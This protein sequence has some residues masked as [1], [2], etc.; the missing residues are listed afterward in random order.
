[1]LLTSNSAEMRRYEPVWVTVD[2]NATESPGAAIV[3]SEESVVLST[4]SKCVS[5]TLWTTA[6]AAQVFAPDTHV[7]DWHVSGLV[8]ESPSLHELPFAF[9]GFEQT[10][11]AGLQVPAT[12][13]WSDAV[14]VTGLPPMQ[15]P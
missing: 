10:P 15:T 3:W 5:A 12:W 9:A 1:M 13:H 14:H 7:P 4:G 2:E 11:V 8:H 6:I